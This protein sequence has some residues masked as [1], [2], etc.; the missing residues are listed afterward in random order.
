MDEL[1]IL[2]TCDAKHEAEHTVRLVE[3]PG[4]DATELLG[5]EEHGGRY[6]FGESAAPGEFLEG[7]ALGAV[8]VGLE[9]ADGEVH[10][11]REDGR[12]KGQG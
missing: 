2:E 8:S 1:A 11:G 7:D 5:D 10:L 12:R 3:G 6:A 9:R 4:A